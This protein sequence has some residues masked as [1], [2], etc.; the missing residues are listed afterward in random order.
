MDDAEDQKQRAELISR[1]F[2][3]LTAKLEDG[4]AIA[5]NCQARLTAGQLRD[6]AAELGELVGE[7]G[8]LAAAV[9]ALLHHAAAAQTADDK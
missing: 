7:A 3:L 9:S 1:L 4:S 6:G 5:A 2:A 8:T